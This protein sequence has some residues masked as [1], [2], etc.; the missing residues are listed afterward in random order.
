MEDQQEPTWQP[1]TML[2]TIAEMVS[3]MLD[4]AAEQQRLLADAP[5]YR[6]DNATL[7]RVERVYS[8]GMSE[9]DV[10]E[11]QIARWQRE[12]PE[13]EGLDALAEN[14][15]RLRPEYQRVL[16]L[17]AQQRGNTIEAMMGKSDLELGLEALL[18][19]Q[20]PDSR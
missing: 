7:D 6:L 18:G 15:A 13:A 3:G 16:D 2:P 19:R 5:A 14:V 20:P 8:E 10:F 11:Q 1:I 9:H 17:A 4:G 12:H